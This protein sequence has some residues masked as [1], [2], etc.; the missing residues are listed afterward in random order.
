MFGKITH[1]SDLDIRKKLLVGMLGNNDSTFHWVHDLL[2]IETKIV[3][4]KQ[5][6]RTLMPHNSWTRMEHKIL[7]SHTNFF[8]IDLLA[9]LQNSLD[10]AMFL[11]NSIREVRSFEYTCKLVFSPGEQ[12]GG[13]CR[14]AANI[15]RRVKRVCVFIMVI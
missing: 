12:R 7:S 1:L 6:M 10:R 4:L 9:I 15:Q 8:L 3:L 11:Y 13:S 5:I 2:V 14:R